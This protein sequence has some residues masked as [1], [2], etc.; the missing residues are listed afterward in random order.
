MRNAKGQ[1]VK[2]F[3]SWPA[4]EFRPGQHWR[5]HQVF[6]DKDWLTREYV[7]KQRSTGDIAVEFGVTKEAVL[8]WLKRHGIKRRTVSEA[9]AVKYW[10]ACGE[11]N[12][13]FGKCGSR[14]AGWRGGRTPWRQ[15]M[16]AQTAYKEFLRS[17]WARDR[18]CRLCGAKGQV[19][20]H[21][22]PVGYAPL[23]I[24]DMGNAVLLCHVCHEKMRGKE[25]RWMKRLYK[26][27]GEARPSKI[28]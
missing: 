4:G 5:K 20:H 1:F 19:V 25:R 2:G 9:R 15:H 12:P 26:L 16:Y 24:L 10:G 3:H 21:I 23:L 6:R 11:K 17:V 8:F 18:R 13:M 7:K 22:D 28:G 14:H 27:I